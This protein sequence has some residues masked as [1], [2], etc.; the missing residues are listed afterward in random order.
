MGNTKW[1]EQVLHNILL[2][3][4]LI[5]GAVLRIPGLGRESL[6]FDELCIVRQAAMG[7]V[8]VV[9]DL[10]GRD[11]HPPLYQWLIQ[12]WTGFA[13]LS[14]F[15]L[16]LPSAIFGIVSILLM[17]IMGRQLTGSRRIGL[18]AGL[19]LAVNPYAAYYTQEAR[20]YS[21]LLMLSLCTAVAFLAYLRRPHQSRTVAA[22]VISSTI[23]AYCHVY[24]I[25]FVSFISMFH[26][27]L[28]TG[29]TRS[30]PPSVN[31]DKG[32]TA[33]TDSLPD[34]LPERKSRLSWCSQTLLHIESS[35][36]DLTWKR[37]FIITGTTLLC[38]AP[39]LPLLLRQTARV[40]SGFWIPKPHISFLASW[41]NSYL[42]NPSLV[43]AGGLLLL[44]GIIT[45]V[46]SA[47]S[48][49]L[50]QKRGGE[51]VNSL[52]GHNPIWPFMFIFTGSW[53]VFMVGIPL[54][55]SMV[56]EPIMMSKYAISVLCPILLLVAVGMDVAGN[57]VSD[58]TRAIS[59]KSCAGARL[60]ALL[61][62]VYASMS[63]YALNEKVHQNNNREDW[64]GMSEVLNKEYIPDSD[65]IILYNPERP[66]DFVWGH[67]LNDQ[68]MSEA[69]SLVCNGDGCENQL[70]RIAL[71]V[72]AVRKGRIWLMGMRAGSRPPDN[73]QSPR[74]QLEEVRKFTGG[75][76]ALYRL[77]I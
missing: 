53:C 67:Y 52:Y 18:M 75:F 56:G 29:L 74:V 8:D 39:L 42:G 2:V 13:G 45:G 28:L 72:H 55:L 20:S 11:V 60:T 58:A 48:D 27:V 61:L 7:F 12:W 30:S 25:L 76:L 77:I 19:L 65:I 66:M 36:H 35:R 69:V 22:L 6:W 57:A 44:S 63:T 16:R 54:L 64:R 43:A 71:S 17:A 23:T 51:R 47:W 50:K 37:F 38:T 26:G 59:K 49:R 1:G 5:L 40:Q 46:Y 4:L 34:S 68:V 21:L 10:A 32:H 73:L 14:E 62:I 24:G 15:S 70:S 33:G 31:R 41:L 3:A 9:E